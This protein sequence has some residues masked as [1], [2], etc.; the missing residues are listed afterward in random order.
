MQTEEDQIEEEHLGNFQ[1]FSVV[2][3]AKINIVK[4]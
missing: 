4:T 2:V 3:F 1:V